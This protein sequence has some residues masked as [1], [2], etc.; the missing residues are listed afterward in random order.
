MTFKL[1]IGDK[2][3]SSWSLRPW[4]LLKQAGIPFEE[5]NLPL[6]TRDTAARIAQYSPSGWVP[7]LLADE[8]P[9]WDSLAI[10]EYVAERFPDK[11]LW[12]E[13]GYA[14]AVARSISAEMHAGFSS[15]RSEMTM[16]CVSRIETPS[17]SD[18]T[19]KDI[20]RIQAIWQE[21]R[22]KFGKGGAFLFGR[23]SVADAM[24]APV[25]T[26]FMTYGVKLDDVSRQYVDTIMALDALQEWLVGARAEEKV[27]A[28][29]G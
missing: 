6:R 18:G 23:F 11:K 21:C 5:I 13:D 26:R 22:R 8:G 27:K 10:C 17:V 7:V 14:R 19:L 3:W 12:P 28:A 2:N 20:A 16:A 29:Q 15:L 1:C 4:I 24:Y 9:V 25:V